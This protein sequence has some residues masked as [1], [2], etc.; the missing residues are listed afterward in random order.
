MGV[1]THLP[2]DSLP[3][4]ILG[5]LKLFNVMFRPGCFQ[6]YIQNY[7]YKLRDKSSRINII[8][9]AKHRHSSDGHLST[10]SCIRITGIPVLDCRVPDL[11]AFRHLSKELRHGRI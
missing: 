10:G 3:T 7:T 6:H 11:S 5:N 9:I 2:T 1:M 4:P 8:L